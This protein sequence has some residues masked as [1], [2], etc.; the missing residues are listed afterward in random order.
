MGAPHWKTCSDL[1]AHD[2]EAERRLLARLDGLGVFLAGPANVVMQLAWPEVG[3]G[4]IESTVHSGQVT[5]HPFKRFRTTIGFLDVALNGSPELQADYREAINRQ[6]RQVRSGPD[7]PVRYNA[8]SRD[9]QLWVASCL[10]YG[11]R[12]AFTTMHGPLT[13]A[14]EEVMLRAAGRF[15]TMLQVPQERWHAD[16]D[17]FAAYWAEGL[18][19]V[20]ID[21]PVHDYL[22]TVLEAR[23]LPFPLDRALGPSLAWVNT[24]F[25]PPEF[26]DAMGLTWSAADERRFR[27]L[28]RAL[29]KGVRPLPGPLRR[30]PLNLMSADL[31]LRRRLGRPLT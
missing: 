2:P 4:V 17:A 8:F 27:A 6:H 28:T 22:M 15:G 26:R 25:L 13:E 30:A 11:L 16:R 19:K 24:G 23:I 1:P 12:D 9:L 10:Y 21:P 5:R 20:S 18:K 7:S 29:G 14:E 3:Y 31:R